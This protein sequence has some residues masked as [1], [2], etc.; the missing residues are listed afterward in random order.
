MDKED[1]LN[2]LRF[3]QTDDGCLG[4]GYTSNKEAGGF[5]IIRW[6]P[7]DMA[8]RLAARLLEKAVLLARKE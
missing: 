6:C 3:I 5:K 2:E 8:D 7:D 1:F 4:V